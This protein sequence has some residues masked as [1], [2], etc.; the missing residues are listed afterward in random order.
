MVETFVIFACALVAGVFSGLM[1]GIG[2]MAIMLISF[3]FLMEIEPHNILIFYVTMVSVDQFFNGITAIV[4]GI[5]GSSMS[6]PTVTEGHRLFKQGRGAEAIMY[7]AI[8]SWITSV[9]SVLLIVAMIPALFL[10]YQM[11]NSHVQAIVFGM[12]SVIIVLVS[13]NKIWINLALF[14]FGSFLAKIG[15]DR[16]TNESFMTFDQT[17]LYGGLPTLPVIATM[18]VVPTLLYSYFNDDRKFRFEGVSVQGYIQS[19][20]GLIKYRATLLRCSLIG[21][22][23]G[24]IPGLT[25]TMS[26]IG[27]YSVERAIQT[28]KGNYEPGNVEC[29]IASEGANNAGSFTQ[30][31]PLLFLGIPITVSEALIYNI[32]D[33]RGYPVTIEWF[34]STF[35]MV[36]AFFLASATIGLFAAGRYVNFIRILDGVNITWVYIGIATFLVAAIFYTGNVQYAGWDHL[37][38]TAILLPIGVLLTRLDTMPLIFGFILH[39]RIFEV[40]TR[41]WIFYT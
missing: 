16:F 27:S 15:Y 33:T 2:G 36:I 21:S 40:W 29:L 30:L 11:F 5:P 23:A 17:W 26:S 12:T 41:I 19:L 25:Y 35:T 9:F 14:A 38:I 20:V 4:W 34:Q 18:F 37:L 13:K 8:T 31:V 3:P 28:R 22:F 1:P 7:S 32:L 6:V 10:L 39:D 24:F